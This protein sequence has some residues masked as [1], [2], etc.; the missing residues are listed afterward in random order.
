VGLR[1]TAIFGIKLCQR[2][3]LRFFEVDQQKKLA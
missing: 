2:T 1:Q 3:G